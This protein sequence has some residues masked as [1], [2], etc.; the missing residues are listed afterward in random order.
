MDETGI[1]T[2]QKPKKVVARKS[3]K[4]IGHITSA[5]RG[6]LMYAVSAAG[7]NVHSYFVFIR[8]NF[9][10]YFYPIVLLVVQMFQ[11]E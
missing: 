7:N 2:V 8:V 6:T 11:C 4:Q 9:R 10:D 1:T 5:E 3:F